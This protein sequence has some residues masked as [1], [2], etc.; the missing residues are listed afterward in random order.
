MTFQ[1]GLIDML[2]KHARKG[3]LVYLAGTM[4][5]RR[6]HK[7]GEDSDRFSTEILPAPGSRIQFLDKA[8]GNS[9]AAEVQVPVNGLPAPGN[10][11]DPDMDQIPF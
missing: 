3:R 8:N 7:D 2:V 1:D 11:A 9:A 5:T 10:D 4:Q 6:W